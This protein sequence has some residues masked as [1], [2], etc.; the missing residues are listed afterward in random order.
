MLE[1][2]IDSG[3]ARSVCPPT[4]C[5]G[6]E[7]VASESSKR[8]DH[9]TSATGA[10]IKNEGER[11][12]FGQ[13]DCGKLL[14]TK[15]AVADVTVPLDSVIQMCDA[16]NVV[17]FTAQGGYVAG[18]NGKIAFAR[19]KDTFVRRTWVRAKRAM[20]AKTAE[21]PKAAKTTEKNA[22]R[23]KTT[24]ADGDIEMNA[25]MKPS[26]TTGSF[27]RPGVPP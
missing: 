13:S 16:G 19:D 12:I 22:A 23:A 2:F 1:S 3:A 4:H 8:G 14:S 26:Q 15:Y 7:T 25:V 5:P 6:F 20:G 24:D 18:P 9:F 27:R 10:Q 21:K 17:V 11:T